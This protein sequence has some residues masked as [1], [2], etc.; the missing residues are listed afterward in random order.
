[1]KLFE[2]PIVEVVNF[3]VE[4]VITES[5]FEEEPGFGGMEGTSCL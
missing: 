3:A 4:D 1:M 2:E 5:V